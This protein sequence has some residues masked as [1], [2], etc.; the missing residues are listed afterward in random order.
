MAF[1]SRIVPFLAGD[2][3]VRGTCLSVSSL[4]FSPVVRFNEFQER[5]GNPL[6]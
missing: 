6:D 1:F 3:A 4:R 5:L 2:D